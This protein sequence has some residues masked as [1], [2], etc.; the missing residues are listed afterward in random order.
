[1]TRSC[2]CRA[3]R[4]SA[5]IGLAG[6]LGRQNPE[7]RLA[8]VGAGCSRRL[9]AEGRREKH[10]SCV[11][12]EKNF[13]A[14]EAFAKAR[15]EGAVDLKGVVF[16]SRRFPQPAQSCARFWPSYAPENRRRRSSTG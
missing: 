5:R 7:R 12:V 14:V 4:S 16:G 1:M 2:V 11:R 13:A 8:V 6:S 9:A 10:A 3:G 15:T